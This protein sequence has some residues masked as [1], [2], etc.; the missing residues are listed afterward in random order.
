MQLGVSKEVKFDVSKVYQMDCCWRF[1]CSL[2]M[3]A[4]FGLKDSVELHFG[5]LP[6]QLQNKNPTI[7]HVP[8]LLKMSLY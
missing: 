2:K 5:S 1:F 4:V 7:N 8:G 3:N 6:L